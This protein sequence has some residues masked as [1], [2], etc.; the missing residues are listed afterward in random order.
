M[1]N[2]PSQ[3]VNLIIEDGVG[4]GREIVV[5]AEGSRIGRSSSNDIVIKD[6]ALSRYHC[7]VFFKPGEGLWAEDLG[8]SNQALLNNKPLTEARIAPGDRLTLGD[9]TLLVLS[10]ECFGEKAADQAAP[11]APSQ[12]PVSAR[13]SEIPDAPGPS[14]ADQPP[15]PTDAPSRRPRPSVILVAVAACL[16]LFVM[17]ALFLMRQEPSV[18]LP[19]PSAHP[20]L[21]LIYEKIQASPQNIFRY[22]LDLRDNKM[23]AEVEDLENSTHI[24]GN[25]QKAVSEEA[26]MELLKAIEAADFFR[27][28]ELSEGQTPN[29]WEV[30]DLSITY[31]TRHRR[32]RMVNVI[33]PEQFKALRLAVEEFAALTLGVS[34]DAVSK[35]DRLDRAH[36]AV[37]RGRDL[38]DQ[39]EVK[40]ENLFYAIRALREA[41]SYLEPVSEKPPDYTE[42]IALLSECE[43]MLKSQF[44]DLKFQVEQAIKI[45]NYQQAIVHLAEILAMIPDSIDDRNAYASKRRIEIERLM[46]K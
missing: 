33:E 44:Y 13:L 4:R 40:N 11:N 10:D 20:S 28:P 5:K 6:P 36:K 12:Q 31:G 17:A 43:T 15:P 39:R 22:A 7:R 1:K 9:T 14:H 8:G 46:K 41:E 3:K 34:A 35:A 42:T 29:I 37:L 38:Y 18:E 2:M 25:Q 30:L 21:V 24:P 23:S 45:K 19:A 16:G 26:Q 32:V 27:L